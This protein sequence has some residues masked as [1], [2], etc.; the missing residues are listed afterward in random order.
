MLRAVIFDFDG[1]LLETEEPLFRAWQETYAAHGAELTLTEWS[2]TIGRADHFDPFSELQRRCG[3]T[4]DRAAVEAARRGRRDELMLAL[5]P[6]AG[7]AQC[8]LEVSSL[9]LRA[10]V[11]SS[12]P[13]DWVDGHLRRLG[14]RGHFEHLSCFDGSGAAKPAPDLYLAALGALGLGA[15]EAVAFE[16]S[17]NGLVAAKAAGLRCV[18]VPTAMTGHMDFAL[19]DAVVERLGQPPLAELLARLDVSTPVPQR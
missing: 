1:L 14:L 10:A 12:S 17:H 3:R 6:C 9:G 11:A 18:V 5:D 2:A 4:L 15:D 19:A 16:D 8:L 13:V 7:A